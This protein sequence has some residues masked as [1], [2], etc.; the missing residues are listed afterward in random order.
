MCV[1]CYLLIDCSRSGTVWCDSCATC[2][3]SLC[4][5][6]RSSLRLGWFGQGLC[7][8]GD[9]TGS[10]CCC[11]WN[12]GRGPMKPLCPSQR[13]TQCF[14]K[15]EPGFIIWRLISQPPDCPDPGFSLFPLT[16]AFSDICPYQRGRRGWRRS[17]IHSGKFSY[18]LE[19]TTKIKCM[20]YL[21]V[22]LFRLFLFPTDTDNWKLTIL[23]LWKDYGN[24]VKDL[25]RGVNWN[26]S[27]LNLC[28]CVLIK[29]FK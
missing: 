8:G 24:T 25:C 9:H 21:W 27:L 20:D 17:P 1:W 15:T 18:W 11:G 5:W 7:I 23:A 29:V 12:R 2:P 10:G 14:C 19:A 3:R 4:S 26:R 16:M 28:V 6:R 22:S 13:T